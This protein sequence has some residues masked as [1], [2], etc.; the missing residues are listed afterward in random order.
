[1]HAYTK[2]NTDLASRLKFVP[3]P[4]EHQLLNKAIEAASQSAQRFR[5]GSAW[6]H[7][8]AFN[9]DLLH[10]ERNML[11]RY[12]SV[13]LSGHTV[14]VA[15]LGK[16]NDWRCSYPCHKCQTSLLRSGVKRLVCLN[17][18]NVPVAFGL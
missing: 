3:T 2:L 14:A 15:R 13:A 12:N 18:H 8:S 9:T 6:A 10:A 1:M 17:E 4:D 11:L 5:V 7:S 16:K